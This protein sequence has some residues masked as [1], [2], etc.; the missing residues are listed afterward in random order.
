MSFTFELLYYFCLNFLWSSW[1]SLVIEEIWGFSK[2]WTAP[3]LGFLR[4]VVSRIPN[5]GGPCIW[6]YAIFVKKTEPICAIFESFLNGWPWT[7]RHFSLYT[8]FLYVITFLCQMSPWMYMSL[9]KKF[10]WASFFSGV[11]L[12]NM[13]PHRSLNFPFGFICS[14]AMVLHD[15]HVYEI[16]EVNWF[17]VKGNTKIIYFHFWHNHRHL[18]NVSIFY[19]HLLVF[20][21][22]HCSLL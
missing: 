20:W 11:F 13:A 1:L 21:R 7:S 19:L 9:P 3:L 22:L 14:N 2:H 6:T 18:R 5:F 15:M 8:P 12:A 4:C 10:S 16:T 17:E